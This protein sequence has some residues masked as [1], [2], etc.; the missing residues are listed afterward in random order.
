MG[1]IF[2]DAKM[3]WQASQAGVAF[4]STLTVGRQVLY[5]HPSEVNY[6]QKVTSSPKGFGSRALSNYRWGN[7]ADDFLREFLG[8]TSLSILDYSSYEGADLVHDLNN[9]VPKELWNRFD[10]IIEAG[11]LEHIFNFPIAI[12]SLMSMAKVGGK[13]FITTPANNLCGHGFYQFSPEV[14]FRLFSKQNGFHL[15]RVMFLPACFPGVELAPIRVAYEVT[16]PAIVRKRVGIVSKNPILMMVEATKVQDGVV[17]TTAPQQS[18]YEM[19]WQQSGM[20]SPPAPHRARS[21]AVYRLL[22][23]FLRTRIMG[24]YQR[25][26]HSFSNSS[27]YRRIKI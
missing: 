13:V 20:S 11:S 24:Y 10:V 27:F 12:G 1:L 19:L 7:Y 8:V 22:P 2:S 26:R 16:D 14:M 9:P 18:D 17:L 25:S 21:K 4:D 5:L 3:L 6:F 23:H 15:D